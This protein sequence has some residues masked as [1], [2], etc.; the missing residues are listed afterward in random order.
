[1]IGGDAEVIEIGEKE[2]E[3]PTVTRLLVFSEPAGEDVLG[4]DAAVEP[5][6][7]VR[8]MVLK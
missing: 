2:P 8:P 5:C 4:L 7:Q 6:A 1:M 3:V